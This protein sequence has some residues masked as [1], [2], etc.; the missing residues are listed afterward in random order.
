MIELEKCTWCKQSEISTEFF[1]LPDMGRLSTEAL[2]MLSK[3]YEGQPLCRYC[4][5][6]FLKGFTMGEQFGK[7]HATESES[8]TSEQKA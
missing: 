5:Q 1:T 8:E 4:S 6:A 3:V 7:D 2:A